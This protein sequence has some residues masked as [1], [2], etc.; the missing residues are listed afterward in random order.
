VVVDLSRRVAAI[1]LSPRA[2]T[3][4]NRQAAIAHNLR[5]VG[6]DPNLRAGTGRNLRAEIGHNHRVAAIG[7]SLL[8]GTDRNLLLA[9]IVLNR[10]RAATDPLKTRGQRQSPNPNREIMETKATEFPR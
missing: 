1:G 2:G 8:A 5:V 9:A 4:L 6:I 10:R 3:G 7:L